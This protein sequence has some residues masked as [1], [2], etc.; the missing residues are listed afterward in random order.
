MLLTAAA[1]P[2]P[3]LADVVLTVHEQRGSTDAIVLPIAE[4]LFGRGISTVVQATLEHFGRHVRSTKYRPHPEDYAGSASQSSFHQGRRL[5]LEADP[6][7]WS[8]IKDSCV[9]VR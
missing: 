2:R 5:R 8:F 3:I 7:H 1:H 4:E 6:E 9:T